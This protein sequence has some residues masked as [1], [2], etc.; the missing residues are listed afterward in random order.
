MAKPLIQIR[1]SGQFDLR[2]EE[3]D[4]ITWVILS[5]CPK[6]DAFLKFVRPDYIGSKATAAMKDAV[7]QFFA[8][9]DVQKYAD[10]YRSAIKKLLDKEER[11]FDDI[12]KPQTLEERKARAKTKLVEFAMNLADNIDQ[13]DDPE[14]VLK[15]ADKCDLLGGDEEVEEVPRRYLPVSPC[16]TSCAYRMF[17]EENTED[18][19]PYCRYHKFGEDNGIHYDKTEILDVPQRPGTEL[20]GTPQAQ[21][22]E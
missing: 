3:M 5:G 9:A 11:N 7:K 20:E 1:P 19:C 2:P 18:M 14:F 17:C 21:N 4:C 13:A 22:N 6:E 10:A 16:L 12:K 15:M 8:M